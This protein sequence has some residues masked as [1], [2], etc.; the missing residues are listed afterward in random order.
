[1]RIDYCYYR[2]EERVVRVPYKKVCYCP[3]GRL[4]PTIVVEK[5]P[6]RIFV[7]KTVIKKQKSAFKAYITSPHWLNFRKY[8][9]ESGRP[10]ACQVCGNKQ[11]QLHHVTYE[12]KGKELL[13]DVIPLCWEHHKEIHIQRC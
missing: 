13:D 1:M 8:Y 2:F 5:V 4:Y 10:Q 3:H 6:E 7:N 12:R 9:K 11:Y